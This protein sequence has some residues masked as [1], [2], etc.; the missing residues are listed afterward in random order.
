MDDTIVAIATPPGRGAIAVLRLS[1]ANAKDI[2]G[3]VI[4]P[5]PIKSRVA[6]LCRI[7]N[8]TAGSATEETGSVPEETIDQAVVTVYN[9]PS[10][11]TGEDTVEIATHGGVIT[12]TLVMGALL[13]NGAREAL[14]GEFTR[15]AVLN[16]KLD[17]VQAEAVGDLIDSSSRAMHSAAIRQLDGGLSRRI[18]ELRS[19]II[20][21][22]ALIAYDIDFPEEDDGPISPERVRVALESAISDLS[23]LLDT[24]PVGEVIRSG[25]TVVIAGHPNAGKSSLFNAILGSERAIVTDIPGTT[26]DAIE[27]SIDT[28]PW[29]IRLIDTAGLR[30]T[31]DVI[32]KMGIE[33]SARYLSSA[34]VVLACGEN[35]ADIESTIQAVRG[36]LREGEEL[37]PVIRVLTKSDI[38]SENNTGQSLHNVRRISSVSGTGIKDLLSDIGNL[39]SE[40]YGYLSVEAPVLT[41]DRHRYAVEQ[42]EMELKTFR[43]IWDSGELPPIVAAVHLRAATH[44]LEEV[45][46]AIKLDDILDRLFSS[47]CVGK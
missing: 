41:R 29:P 24:A 47:F 45:V 42:A 8:K 19:R 34:H 23:A 15:R 13:R 40:K 46:G 39:L 5:W 27:A 33:V 4:R 12:P 44:A 2:A 28:S 22:E 11:Y 26:R 16:G 35:E 43:E 30:E 20:E 14:T 21:I 37:P 9:G 3:R 25:A 18:N 1:G 36:Y 17:L 32:E 7:V 10:S 38:S 6:T 31:T